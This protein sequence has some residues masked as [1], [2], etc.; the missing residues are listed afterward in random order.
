MSTF[1]NPS[2]DWALHRVQLRAACTH[3]QDEQSNHSNTAAKCDI[4]FSYG[5]PNRAKEDFISGSKNVDTVG[6]YLRNLHP[7]ESYQRMKGYSEEAVTNKLSIQS[8]NFFTQILDFRFNP[9]NSSDM[10][11]YINLTK[12]KMLHEEQDVLHWSAESCYV[13]HSPYTCG[14]KTE[15]QQQA[16]DCLSS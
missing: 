14:G 9:Y 5:N 4:L 16:S 3:I 11:D 15:F 10:K 1:I 8:T 7:E 12:S 13:Q 2:D 6:N